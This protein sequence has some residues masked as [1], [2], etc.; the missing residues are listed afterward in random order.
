MQKL[1]HMIDRMGTTN[2]LMNNEYP[3]SQPHPHGLSHGWLWL[4]RM[5]NLEPVP[6]VT[7]TA[8][9][10]FLKV[11]GSA[12]LRVYKSQFLKLLEFLYS[13]YLPK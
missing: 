5:L 2:D 13:K 11:A 6:D 12:L 7:A 8:L 10:A 3:L 4:S 1:K 9:E